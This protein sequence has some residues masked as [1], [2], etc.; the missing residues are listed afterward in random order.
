MQTLTLEQIEKRKQIL[1]RINPEIKPFID[2]T[3]EN[4]LIISQLIYENKTLRN[5]DYNIFNI[6]EE[7][8]NFVLSLTLY[9]IDTFTFYGCYHGVKYKTKFE[10]QGK[11]YLLVWREPKKL[12]FGY[13]PSYFAILP[14]DT[15]DLYTEIDRPILTFDDSFFM[16]TE[17]YSSKAI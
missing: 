13:R 5:D 4:D 11:E 15:K 2:M 17:V 12:P 10:W 9:K 16:K 1:N 7:F 6:S 3:N 14:A 8:K